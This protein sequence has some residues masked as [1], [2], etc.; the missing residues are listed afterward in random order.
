MIQSVALSAVNHL[1]RQDA[2]ASE[3]LRAFAGKT[4]TVTIEPLATL[5][6][7]IRADGL[8]ERGAPDAA[9]DLSVT[10]AAAAVPIL[11]TDQ[12]ALLSR[13]RIDGDA[14]FASAV[15]E[16]AGEVRWDAEDDLARLIGDVAAHRVATTGAALA[17]WQREAAG[18]AARNVA[19][20]ATEEAHIVAST[21]D[22]TRL[23]HAA[24][25]LARAVDALD[26]RI[27][28]LAARIEPQAV[29]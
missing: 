19:E 22:L 21:Q 10:V 25:D 26:A 4:I 9:P 11:L 24:T 14:A 15:Q 28:G 7:R 5:S 3:R 27:A 23:T 2:W 1:L 16:V 12:R 17:S 6:L 29:R 13:A 20:Y 8:L 18:R